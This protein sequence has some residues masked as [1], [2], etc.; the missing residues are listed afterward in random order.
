MASKFRNL[1]ASNL[2]NIVR[3][4]Q[5]EELNTGAR[6]LAGN[7]LL[8]NRSFPRI[9]FQLNRKII[10]RFTPQMVEDVKSSLKDCS[11]ISEVTCHDSGLRFDVRKESFVKEVL[12]TTSNR[13]KGY[14][15]N[16]NA[17]FDPDS[18]HVI[19][20][21]SSPNIAKPFHI[22]HF[23]STI[24][25]S[26]VANI[27]EAVGHRVTRL[28]WLG[29]WGTQFGYLLAGMDQFNVTIDH[30][31]EDTLHKLLQIY[32]DANRLGEA[33]PNFAKKAREKF[34]QLEEGSDPQLLE[35]WKFFREFSIKELKKVYARLDI[36]FD[37][38]SGESFYSK[39]KADH[40][41]EML[42]EQHLLKRKDGCEVVELPNT[43]DVKIIKSDG[44]S[45]YI[46]RDLAAAIHR[47]EQYEFDRM[48]YVVDNDQTHHLRNLFTILEKM[49]LSWANQCFHA[50]FG[51]IK[52]LSTR[53]GNMVL[54]DHIIDEAKARMI[55]EQGKTNTTRVFG[56]EAEKAA[57]ILGVSALIVADFK[58]RRVKDYKFSWDTA[59]SPKG[60]TGV[61]LQYLHA[62][63]NSLLMNSGVEL[64]TG[65][66]T[67]PLTEPSALQL[68][69]HLGQWD[70][71]L[72]Q[73]YTELDPS[74]IVRYLFKLCN[75]T[76]KCFK[77]LTVKGE[78]PDLARARILL[79][80]SS[81]QVLAEALTLIGVQPLDKM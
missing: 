9:G 28:N 79:F 77:E 81:K 52:G 34:Q 23:R 71:C 49:G 20:E 41:L 47:F 22:G 68:V 29:D 19:V 14:K 6:Y 30:L 12:H 40:V 45:L 55:D 18:K 59:L 44:S 5:G 21:F 17:M 75:F 36:E 50:R 38:Y 60:D 3:D 64:D 25:G 57:Q 56:E 73:S 31:K 66:N 65:A 37:E 62:R 11:E 58:Q 10:P 24:I 32:I 43:T 63:L 48:V 7:L 74:I 53:K 39:D 26:F 51:K 46:T 54:L 13:P 2:S 16:R 70:E 27:H 76:N 80:Y 42:K 33:D 61:K 78:D 69:F 67:L 4:I 35:Y 15:W 1:I 72:K 8:D